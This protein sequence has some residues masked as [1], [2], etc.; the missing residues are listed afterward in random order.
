M[1][2]KSMLRPGLLA[3]VFE[4]V[5]SIG[6]AKANPEPSVFFGASKAPV[7]KPTRRDAA[8]YNRLNK[9]R[10]LKK[11]GNKSRNRNRRSG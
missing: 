8:F 1:N 11:T 4:Q 5:K 7:P 3:D 10:A 6:P 2:E 9:R